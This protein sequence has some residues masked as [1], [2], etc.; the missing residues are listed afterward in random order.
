MDFI[1]TER[2]LR[3]LADKQTKVAKRYSLIRKEYGD[4]LW[5]IRVLLAPHMDDKRFQKA[6]FEK[7]IILLMAET[8]ENHKQEVYKFVEDLTKLREQ[9]KGIAYIYEANADRIRSLQSLMRYARTND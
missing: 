2:E 9:Y 1:E 3:D 8:P 4:A 6:S 5:S 7:G